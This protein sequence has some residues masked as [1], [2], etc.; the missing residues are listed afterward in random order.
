[1]G[2][3]DVTHELVRNTLFLIF[4]LGFYATGAAAGAF[5]WITWNIGGSSAGVRAVTL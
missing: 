2:P 3:L 4:S 1:M 5:R